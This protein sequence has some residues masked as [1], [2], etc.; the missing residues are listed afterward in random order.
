MDYRW[1]GCVHIGS[2]VSYIKEKQ[3]FTSEGGRLKSLLSSSTRECALLSHTDSKCP[4]PSYSSSLLCCDI[5]TELL[6]GG[7]PSACACGAPRKVVLGLWCVALSARPSIRL[8]EVSAVLFIIEKIGH[9]AVTLSQK[10]TGSFCHVQ[11]EHL[12]AMLAV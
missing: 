3:A 9:N 4:G 8:P 2:Q 5:C 10:S 6:K 7:P 1:G 11:W 12:P